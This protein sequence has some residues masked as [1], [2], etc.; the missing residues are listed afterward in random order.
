[1]YTHAHTHTR[2]RAHTHTGTSALKIDHSVLKAALIL[3]FPLPTPSI[4][5]CSSRL[6]EITPG[7][8]SLLASA[9]SWSDLSAAAAMIQTAV[10]FL[11]E[12]ST[13]IFVLLSIS[14]ASGT[15]TFSSA[16]SFSWPASLIT[17]LVS[18]TALEIQPTEKETM[19]H[20]FDTETLETL[21]Q[22][23]SLGFA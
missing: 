22:Q 11:W 16:S 20:F 18:F 23:L 5:H 21:F 19:R 1:M 4:H 8:H 15:F 14:S 6:F 3:P 7:A 2:T 12:K 10:S 9:L 17:R 13:T